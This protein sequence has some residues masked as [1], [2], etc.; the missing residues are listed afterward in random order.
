MRTA[1]TVLG[2]LASSF[3]LAT[4]AASQAIPTP[5]SVLGFTV[6]Q[7]LNLRPSGYEPDRNNFV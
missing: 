6:G 5:E 1:T 3:A 4:S 7:D 2:I